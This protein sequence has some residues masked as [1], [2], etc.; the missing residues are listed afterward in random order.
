MSFSVARRFDPVG[1]LAWI[2]SEVSE[3]YRPAHSAVLVSDP[4]WQ[5]DMDYAT[6]WAGVRGAS[7]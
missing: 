3:S 5:M 7:W 4:W 6:A 1:L 2:R